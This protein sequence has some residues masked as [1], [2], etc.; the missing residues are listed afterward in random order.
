M[1]PQDYAR[2]RVPSSAV[3][4]L[5]IVTAAHAISIGAA[6]A[7]LIVDEPSRSAI[8]REV[9]STGTVLQEAGGDDTGKPPTWHRIE[10]GNPP[11]QD[12]L[13]HTHAEVF[14]SF[15][16]A[17]ASYYAEINAFP[18]VPYNNGAGQARI[19]WNFPFHKHRPDATFA[20]HVDGGRLQLVDY[21]SVPDLRTRIDLTIAV[22]GDISTS[23]VALYEFEA[24]ANLD[25]H[26][27]PP[28]STTF[29]PDWEGF[30]ISS[31][32]YT[33]QRAPSPSTNVIGATLDIPEQDISLDLTAILADEVD[34]SVIVNLSME[35]RATFL[36][37]SAAMA[38]FRDPTQFD[39]PDPLAGSSSITYSGLTLRA[40]VPE[41]SSWA[42]LAAGLVLLAPMMRRHLGNRAPR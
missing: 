38:V 35:A 30:Q 29:F 40:P 2:L 41:P 37:G 25:G 14:S 7:Q 26:G 17:T 19:T 18:G 5:L 3:L 16:N 31:A 28:T 15:E 42:L 10:L 6:S 8:V 12:V 32:N 1:S 11:Q 4:R 21:L 33:E 23:P 36:D 34:F 13:G 9:N 20:M 27:G 22:F 24:F 39:S